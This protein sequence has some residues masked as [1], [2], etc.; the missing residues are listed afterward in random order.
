[1][2]QGLQGGSKMIPRSLPAMWLPS[3]DLAFAKG[4]GTD[5]EL[6]GDFTLY[7]RLRRA[8]AL[9]PQCGILA[10][11][12]YLPQHFCH[13]ASASTFVVG[14]KCSILILGEHKE[15]LASY[16]HS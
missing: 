8:G 2:A 6:G 3:Q 14:T 11:C 12:T 7:I 13:T 4:D 16:V 10:F 15:A 5:N 9:C 1:M